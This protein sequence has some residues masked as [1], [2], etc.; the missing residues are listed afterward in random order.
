MTGV[1]TCALPISYVVL[2]DATGSMEL[3]V[4]SR[5]L[6]E[7]G[8]YL[9]ANLPVAVSGRVSVRDEKAPQLMVDRVIPLGDAPRRAEGEQVLWVRLPDGGA[10][11]SWFKKLLNMFPGENPAVVYLADSKKKLQSHCI[12]HDALL[13]ELRETLGEDSVVLKAR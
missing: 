1:Q 3:L 6:T 5:T 7:S 13:A 10:S 4:F 11:F 2:E 8:A 12:L 9:K